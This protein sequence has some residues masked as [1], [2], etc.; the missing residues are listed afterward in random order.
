MDQHHIFDDP[1]DHH[2]ATNCPKCKCMCQC[3]FL[4]EVHR[5]PLP[6]MAHREGMCHQVRVPREYVV[7]TIQQLGWI[8]YPSFCLEE[9]SGV[10]PSTTQRLSIPSRKYLYIDDSFP[11]R[12]KSHIPD[13]RPK[14]CLKRT[15]SIHQV[16]KKTTMLGELALGVHL[17]VETDTQSFRTAFILS[18]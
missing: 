4:Q 15:I 17:G 13:Q 2:L 1:L 6:R 10:S 8:S 9:T 5:C 16:V 18:S 7:L 12:V 3:F 14:R 11:M